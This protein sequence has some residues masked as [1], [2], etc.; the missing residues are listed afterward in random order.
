[1]FAVDQVLWV[2]LDNL[3]CRVSE[4]LLDLLDLVGLM[5]NPV[6]RV[7]LESRVNRACQAVQGPL[8]KQARPAHQVNKVLQDLWASRAPV[9]TLERG[10][11]TGNRGHRVSQAFQDQQD[12]QASRDRW[13]TLER[14]GL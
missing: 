3:V 14:L 12:S 13:A 6:V 10:V 1:M 11:R 8:G 5:D 7:N 4:D 9:V 2:G